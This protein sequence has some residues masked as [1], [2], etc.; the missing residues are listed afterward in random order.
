MKINSTVW[1]L[2]CPYFVLSLSN[3]QFEDFR[4]KIGFNLKQE[5]SYYEELLFALK[6]SG[7]ALEN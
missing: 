7:K 1:S 2:L 6:W 3:V 5:L 4:L